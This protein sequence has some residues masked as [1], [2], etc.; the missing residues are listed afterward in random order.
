M[1]DQGTSSTVFHLSTAC[2]SLLFRAHWQGARIKSEKSRLLLLNHP[3]ISLISL[4]LEALLVI[5]RPT[6]YMRLYLS[7]QFF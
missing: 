1:A 3:G 5:K 7:V 4:F 2:M 6:A